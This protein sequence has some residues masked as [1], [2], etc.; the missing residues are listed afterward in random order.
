MLQAVAGSSSPTALCENGG[1][2]HYRGVTVCLV[3]HILVV[4]IHIFEMD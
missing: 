1:L 4:E 3:Q 2:P